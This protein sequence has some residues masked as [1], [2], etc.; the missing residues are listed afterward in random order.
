MRATITY[1]DK[2]L[3]VDIGGVKFSALEKATFETEVSID[4]LP[5]LVQL[6]ASALGILKVMSQGEPA[7]RASNGRRRPGRPPKAASARRGG[8]R[9]GTRTGNSI[10]SGASAFNPR[11]SNLKPD[12]VTGLGLDRIPSPLWAKVRDSIKALDKDTWKDLRSKWDG[13]LR[14]STKKDDK[15]LEGDWRAFLEAA[16]KSAK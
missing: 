5:K 3:T 2:G 8:K 14:E 10:W 6:D 16:K 12:E 4:E 9:S 15:T 11:W 1:T 7:P 13:R